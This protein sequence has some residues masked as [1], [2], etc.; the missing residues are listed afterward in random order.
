MTTTF[1]FGDLHIGVRS[2]T[3]GTDQLVRRLLGQ[4]LVED[5]EAP[6]NY[7]VILEDRSG[8]GRGLNLLYRSWTTLVRS[9]HPDRVLMALVAHLDQYGLAPATD[10]LRARAVALVREGRAILVPDRVFT[11]TDL[12]TPRLHRKGWQFVDSPF[13]DVD[14]DRAELVVADPNIQG[15]LMGADSSSA[16]REPPPVAPGRYPLDAWAFMASDQ[17][18]PEAMSVAAGTARAVAT[19]VEDRDRDPMQTARRL[20]DLFHQVTPYDVGSA[21]GGDLASKLTAVPS[22]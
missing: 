7:S 22:R 1:R 10:H 8:V 4:H 2:D 9:R 13:V 20:A 3:V 12:L 11:W 5:V 19:V 15:E 16:R 18:S 17:P 6:A 21:F 14:P